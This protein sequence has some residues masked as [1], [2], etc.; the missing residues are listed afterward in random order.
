MVNGGGV[1]EPVTERDFEVA[2]INVDGTSHTSGPVVQVH[3][4]LV[5]SAALGDVWGETGC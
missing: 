4:T 1:A 2:E 3:G 5:A